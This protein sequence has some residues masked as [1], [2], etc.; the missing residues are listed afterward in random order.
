MLVVLKR[1]FTEPSSRVYVAN[2]MKI[3]TT[4]L[5]SQE[6]HPTLIDPRLA[7]S[8]RERRVKL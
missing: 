2:F 8:S 6:C 5:L 4:V 1:L 7:L 3:Q